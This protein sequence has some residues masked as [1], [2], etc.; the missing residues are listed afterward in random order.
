MSA[1]RRAEL[2][3]RRGVRELVFDRDGHRCQAAGAPLLARVEARAR[4]GVPLEQLR[5]A[6][7]ELGRCYGPL[8]PH[9][10]L[11]ESQGGAYEASNLVALCSR[12][13][14]WVEDYPDHARALGLVVKSWE[15]R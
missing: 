6:V 1:K 3:A 14:S 11:K 12:H 4:L 10:L 2:D 9:H 7:L 15:A 13:N 8:T 5:A